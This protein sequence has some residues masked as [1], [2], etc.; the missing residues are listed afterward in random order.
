MTTELIFFYNNYEE[1]WISLLIQIKSK[2]YNAMTV[3]LC[4]FGGG[5]LEL[6]WNDLR[7]SVKWSSLVKYQKTKRLVFLE[8]YTR[9]WM[10]EKVKSEHIEKC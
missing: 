7:K 5:G 3:F 2:P 8:K 6:Y 9:K 10:N 1:F 4:Y